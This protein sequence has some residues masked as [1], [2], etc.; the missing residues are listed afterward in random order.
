MRAQVFNL[1]DVKIANPLSRPRVEFVQPTNRH[2]AHL[3]VDVH[4]LRL[5]VLQTAQAYTR[6][7]CPA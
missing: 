5:Q 7:A 3:L 1:H 2:C 6:H 4:D